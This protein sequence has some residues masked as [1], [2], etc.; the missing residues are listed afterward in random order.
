MT[1]TE[2]QIIVKT[3]AD[4]RKIR[5]ENNVLSAVRIMTDLIMI[6]SIFLGV[7]NS[8]KE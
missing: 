4:F 3:C 7:F 8:I 5:R 6:D 2:E 1:K